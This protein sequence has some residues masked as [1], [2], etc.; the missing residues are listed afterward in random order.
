MFHW[1]DAKG[2]PLP[3]LKDLPSVNS[4]LTSDKGK[5]ELDDIGGVSKATAC[6]ILREVTALQTQGADEFFVEPEFDTHDLMRLTDDG[7]GMVSLIELSKVQD[8]P[9]LFSTFLMWLLADLYHDLPEI[10]DADKP[11]L[12]FFVTQRPTDVPSA[13]LAQLGNR[14]QRALRA[15]T[16]GDATAL[17]KTVKT[18]P[19]TE[20]YDL[21]QALTQLGTGEAIITVMS[22]KG[23]MARSLFGTGRCRR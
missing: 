21:A 18:Y 14:V 4:Y 10:G 20:N 22:E 11:K 7:R 5:G 1:T 3:D 19:K 17:A 2:L 9:A 15:F 23:A 12:V 6:V 13:I 16:P 8:R